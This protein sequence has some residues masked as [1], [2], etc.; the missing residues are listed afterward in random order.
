MGTL[1]AQVGDTKIGDDERSVI[2]L[3]ILGPYLR[4]ALGGCS[5]RSVVDKLRSARIIYDPLELSPDS[6]GRKCRKR[7]STDEHP[8]FNLV[9][10]EVWQEANVT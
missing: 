9:K 1:G 8:R 6:S 3:L 10:H 4:D 5:L 7:Y 2:D